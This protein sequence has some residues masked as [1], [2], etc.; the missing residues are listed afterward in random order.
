MLGLRIKLEQG[1]SHLLLYLRKLTVHVPPILF[2]GFVSMECSG[3]GSSQRMGVHD[4]LTYHVFTW[5][6]RFI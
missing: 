2:P 4:L 5:V 1:Y 6:F 3:G